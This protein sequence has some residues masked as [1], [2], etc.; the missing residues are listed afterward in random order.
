ME[1]KDYYNIL[2]VEKKSTQDEIKR[3][4]RKL[5]RKY[6]PDVNKAPNAEEHFKEIGEAYTVLKDPEKRSA[7]DQLG[8]NW[9]QGQD[10]TP[11]PNW[12]AGYE[13]S[14]QERQD[15]QQFSDFFENLFGRSDT[16][17]GAY[18]R[19]GREF[20][21]DG[22]DHFAKILINLEDTY[23]GTTKTIT[24]Q[25]SG[26]DE[27]GRLMVRPHTLNVRI[28][29][30][31]IE[32]QRI[33]LAGKGG[34]PLGRGSH[35]DLYLEIILAPHRIFKVDKRDIYMELP[36]TPWEAALGASVKVPILANTVSLKVPPDSQTGKKIRLK[37]KGLPGKSSGDCYVTFKIITPKAETEEAKK[38]YR[39]MASKMN[40]N[41][42]A[43]LQ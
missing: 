22:E 35:G 2:E 7:Y 9:R 10:F 5:A 15:A 14:F 36:I 37:G 6:H 3:S 18:H 1:Y 33:R 20:H 8:E 21:A 23:Y 17:K 41:P 19:Q 11:P 39:E 13:F 30:G 4:Y 25:V 38:I 16:G 27:N 12:D 31:V 24:L 43:E 42:R 28:P 34:P 26:L 29:K 32:G 40:F